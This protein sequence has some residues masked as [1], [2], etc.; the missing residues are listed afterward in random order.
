MSAAECESLVQMEPSVSV[1]DIKRK[2][3]EL[4]VRHD[5]ILVLRPSL[6]PPLCCGH[7]VL[8]GPSPYI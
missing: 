8:T 4:R 7:F 5:H 6:P 3:T 1:G 2:L